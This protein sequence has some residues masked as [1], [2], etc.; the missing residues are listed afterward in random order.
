MNNETIIATAQLPLMT[1]PPGRSDDAEPTAA[2]PHAIGKQIALFAIAS[3]SVTLIL[4]GSL[5]ELIRSAL[6]SLLG[7]LGG[8]LVLADAWRQRLWKIEG[9]RSLLNMTP[10]TWGICTALLPAVGLPLYLLHRRRRSQHHGSHLLLALVIITNGITAT[11][12]V[13]AIL[14]RHR[15]ATAPQHKTVV[16]KPAR[17]AVQCRVDA[18]REVFACQASQTDGPQPTKACWTIRGTCDNRTV[19]TTRAC[20]TTRRGEQRTVDIPITAMQNVDQCDI[21]ATLNVVNLDINQPPANR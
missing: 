20:T 13:R 2:S 16:S 12:N 18:E 7:L 11:A 9:Q 15:T 3:V 4:S 10:A 8:S 21:L 5:D 19:V 14:R 1:P 6:G 17:V